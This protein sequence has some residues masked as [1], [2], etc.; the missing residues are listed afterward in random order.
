MFVC[1]CVCVCVYNYIYKIL[2]WPKVHLGFSITLHEKA[3]QTLA[4]PICNVYSVE[5]DAFFNF[6][7][8]KHL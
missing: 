8:L 7:G 3:K 4:N 2:S 1:V 5:S 6:F